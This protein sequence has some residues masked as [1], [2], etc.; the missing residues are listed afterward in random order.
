MVVSH[1]AVCEKS[2]VSGVGVTP[3]G[4]G[5]VTK[6]NAK[7]NPRLMSKEL[8]LVSSVPKGCSCTLSR[9]KEPL[10]LEGL[11]S[12]NSLWLVDSIKVS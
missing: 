4:L 6:E 5:K 3:T 7:Y 11:R 12:E 10:E 9:S 2:S 8:V 1:A